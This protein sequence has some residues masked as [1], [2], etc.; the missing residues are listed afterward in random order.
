MITTI[1]KDILTVSTGVIVHSANCLGK[2]GGLSGAIARKY[3]ENERMYKQHVRATKEPIM[4]LGSIYSVPVA[5]DLIV[6]N[7]FGQFDVGTNKQRT[8][9]AALIAGFKALANAC[10][11]GTTQQE[12]QRFE[13]CELE[14]MPIVLRDIYI[15][16]KIGCGLGGADWSTVKSIIHEVFDRVAHKNIYICKYEKFC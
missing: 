11:R 5:D 12:V 15:P 1:N 6:A 13:G 2:V 7:L 16:Y 4:L 8:E 14:I 9:Y 3:P 10:F